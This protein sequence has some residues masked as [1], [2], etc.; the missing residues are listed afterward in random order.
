[1]YWEQCLGYPKSGCQNSPEDSVRENLMQ[2]L[3][4]ELVHS[5][6]GYKRI[7]RS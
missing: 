3:V 5:A 7:Q 1:M 4:Q 2:A 6:L